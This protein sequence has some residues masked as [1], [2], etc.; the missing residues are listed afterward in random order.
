[1][2]LLIVQSNFITTSIK[3]HQWIPFWWSVFKLPVQEKQTM[4]GKVQFTLS[5]PWRHTVGVELLLHPFLALALDGGE[6]STSRPV[7]LTPWKQ[8][9]YTL[10]GRLVGS[11]TSLDVLENI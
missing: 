2:K 6:W 1:M 4:K 5:M 7:H 10:N 9:Q 3:T 8:P 11:Q